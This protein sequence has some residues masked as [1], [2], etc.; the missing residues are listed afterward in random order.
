MEMENIRRVEAILKKAFSF[1]FDI[2]VEKIS[3]KKYQIKNKYTKKPLPERLRLLLED[4]GPTFVKFGQLLSIR[5]DLIPQEYCE[6]L[7]KLQDEVKQM[8]FEKVKEIIE[9]EYGKSMN[10]LFK[11][12]KKKPIASASISQ[13]HKAVLHNGK[14]VA[15]K[16]K[17]EN[18]EKTMQKDIKIMKYISEK[19]SK[20]FPQVAKYRPRAI[21]EE[22]E[23]WTLQ[24][25]DFR[26]EM[27]NILISK[28]NFKNNSRVIIPEPYKEL[29]TRNILVT[30]FIDGTELNKIKKQDKNIEKIFILGFE[31]IM[32]QVFEHGFFHADPHPGN[33]LIVSKK[34]SLNL[35]LVDFGIIG[36][37]D[38]KT[39]QELINLFLGFIEDDSDLIVDTF[40]RMTNKR[41]SR[42]E[43]KEKI[44]N[45]IFQLK[46]KRISDARISLA[47]E[48]IIHIARE[49]DM[50]LPVELVLFG[51]TIA[52]LEGV[53]LKYNPNF[54]FYSHCKAYLEKLIRHEYL[55]RPN[56]ID[57]YKEYA[58]ARQFIT[59]IIEKVSQG[60][61]IPKDI[62]INIDDSDIKTLALEIDRSSNRITYG[63]I[64]AAMIL[65]AAMIMNI[66]IGPYI[67]NMPLFSF[68]AIV[69]ALIFILVLLISIFKEHALKR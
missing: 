4:L 50:H 10:K 68:V 2:F 52:T 40:M 36:I 53:A 46:A 32:T 5:P 39:K 61:L 1:G 30:D 59:D 7:A 15:V 43:F 18:I 48:R 13:V 3:G 11:D 17:R 65:A 29:C 37:I 67:F 60:E 20:H 47:L 51:K 49:Y 69:I 12:F 57:F 54:D 41:I 24:E 8:E 23:R 44:K 27:E 6:E 35:V 45:H 22:F 66:N 26:K 31:I 28:E 21:V 16:I 42:S 55:K 9:K 62:K 25:L 14:I 19:L 63:L 34:K 64:S 38:E 58:K 56:M 33:I